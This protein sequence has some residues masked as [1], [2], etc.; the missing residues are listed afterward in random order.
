MNSPAPIRFENIVVRFSDKTILDGVS[1]S[2]RS[3]EI[4]ALLGPSGAGKTTLLRVALGFLRPVSGEMWIDGQEISR[5]DESSLFDVR[6]NLGIVFQDGALFTSMSVAENVAFPIAE[7]G[8]DDAEVKRRVL[9]VL[10]SVGLEELADRM[11]DQLSGGQAQRVAVARAII[12]EPRVMLYDEPTQGLEPARALDVCDEILRLSKT[13]VA[14]IVI[15]HQ[16]EYARQ[17]A[18]RFALL[19]RGRIQF[20]GT[21]D[22]MRRLDDPFSR[23][24]F[25]VLEGDRFDATFT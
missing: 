9:E 13:G 23:S 4:V 22:E 1:L 7:E 11:P 3:G 14:S 6:R 15:T 12:A 20:D 8:L 19:E 2:V 17:F 16:L 5:L 18:H 21:L 10:G 25:Q 24:F